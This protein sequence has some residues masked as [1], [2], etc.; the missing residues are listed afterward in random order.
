MHYLIY[1]DGSELKAYANASATDF[2]TFRNTLEP[3]T[4]VH[5]NGTTIEPNVTE[6]IAE[7]LPVFIKSMHRQWLGRAV[8]ISPTK[9]LEDK[10]V[11][12][13]PVAA[14]APKAKKAT[15]KKKAE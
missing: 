13:E 8:F 15:R 4:V 5:Q 6:D 2:E 3:S 14:P 9:T 7:V 1:K 12:E 10:Q 11:P